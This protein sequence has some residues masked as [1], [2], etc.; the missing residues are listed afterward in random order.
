[1]YEEVIALIIFV[2]CYYLAITRKFKL[3]Y[4][5]IISGTILLLLGIISPSEAVQSIRWDVLGIYWGFMMISMIFAESGL[6]K[7]IS[8]K[9]IKHVKKEK[10][11]IFW[12]CAITTFLS[13]FMENVGVVLMI[14]PVAIESAKN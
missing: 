7:L 1:M 10:Y 2:L 8:F 3:A 14:A 6:P 4:I 11:V 5:S 13:A 12:L 9:I